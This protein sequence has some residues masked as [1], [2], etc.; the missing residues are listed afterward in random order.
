MAAS[1]AAS[2]P[3]AKS[4][5]VVGTL[6]TPIRPVASSIRATSVNVPPISTPTRHAM[7]L[8]SPRTGLPLPARRRG[9]AS[10]RILC[11]LQGA[12]AGAVVGLDVDQRHATL[13]DL[14]LRALQ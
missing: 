14:L 9:Y 8:C 4:R 6:A 10:R 7:L 5:G 1:S 11:E 13:V 2:T 3:S 12:R